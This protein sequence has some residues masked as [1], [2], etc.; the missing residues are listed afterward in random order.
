MPGRDGTGPLWMGAA[1]RRG[2]GM[3]SNLCYRRR[4]NYGLENG[5]GYGC[6]FGFASDKEFLLNRKEILKNQLDAVEKELNEL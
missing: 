1:N 4:F 6:R 3:R 5:H 2:F